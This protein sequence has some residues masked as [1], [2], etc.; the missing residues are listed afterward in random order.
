VRARE[1]DGLGTGGQ[2]RGREGAEGV[3]VEDALDI[4]NVSTARA[5]LSGAPS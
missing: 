1:P 5:T 3:D 4:G 2:G